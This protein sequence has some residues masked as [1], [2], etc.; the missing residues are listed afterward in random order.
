[1]LNYKTGKRRIESHVQMFDWM[2]PVSHLQKLTE[3]KNY[4]AER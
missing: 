3:A 2:L 1:M 4:T